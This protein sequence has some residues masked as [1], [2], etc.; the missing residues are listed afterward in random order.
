MVT[1][2]V[3][4]TGVV[5]MMNCGEV[6][7]PAGTVT[8]AGTVTLES[9]LLRATTIPLAGAGPFNETVFMPVM[10]LPPTTDVGYSEIADNASGFTVRTTVLV[11]PLYVAEIVTGVSAVTA[12]VP[13]VNVGETV[14]PAA[15]VTD[16]GTATPGSLLAS[17][18]TAPPAGALPFRVT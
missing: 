9:L 16:A 11:T 18:T 7:D 14:V 8:D 4:D 17:A 5:V 6:L 3:A 12:L 13:M 10:A 2:S 1:V 15:T